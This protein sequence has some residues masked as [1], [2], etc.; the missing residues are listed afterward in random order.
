MRFFTTLLFSSLILAFSLEIFA[1]SDTNYSRVKV[2][3]PSQSDIQRVKSI[4]LGLDHYHRGRDY[5]IAEISQDALERLR[6]SG[7]SFSILIEDVSN[8]YAERAAADMELLDMEAMNAPDGFFFFF[9]GGFLTL[10]EAYENLESMVEAYP[11]LISDK[12]Q[13][14]ESIEGRPIYKWILTANADQDLP[15]ALYT[16]L[17]HAREPGS[18]STVL[19]YMWWLLEQYGED[20]EATFILDNRKLTVV[21][22]INPDGYFYNETTHPNGGGMFRGN[23]R[24]NNGG[25]IGVDLNRNFG[26]MEAWDSPLGGSSTIPGSQ[27]Y[28]GTA[29]F[30]EPET[31]ALRDLTERNNFK[32]AFN[33]HTFSN[34][35]I[36]PFGFRQEPTPDSLLYFAYAEAMTADND[37][38][39]GLDIEAV[40]YSTR[41]NSDDFMY[42]EN[43]DKG[44]IFAFTPEVGSFQDF[45]WPLPSRIVP[46]A[47]ENLSANKLLAYYAGPHV[48]LDRLAFAD[49]QVIPGRQTNVRFT[50][51]DLV[52]IGQH[53]AKNVRMYFETSVEGVSIETV[54]EFADLQSVDTLS[55]ISKTFGVVVSEDIEIGA[56]IPVRIF[57]EADGSYTQRRTVFLRASETTSTEFEEGIPEVFSI[58]A[59]YPNPFNPTTSFR[60]GLPNDDRIQITV[61]SID[62]RKVQTITNNT[63]TSGWHTF[64]FDGSQLSSGMYLYRVQNSSEVKTG[65]MLLVK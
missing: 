57:V 11:E 42:L 2:Y 56:T 28:R 7:A 62:G 27:T 6:E 58:S 34:L 37:Y 19:Y 12:I 29:P 9:M 41:G 36:Y 10:S 43:E 15:Q 26:P 3:T 40:N 54:H 22:I 61:Y 49:T 14:G 16:S 1:Q 65:K 25:S 51:G 53:E 33:Y 5:F 21:P 18:L 63:Y 8:Y 23:R 32:T 55:I 35:L 60:V 47:Q 46:L 31:A 38:F 64:K 24:V 17:I 20:P 13:I 48:M 4:D 44:H 50:G 30:S 59:N 39:A 52:N 45:F